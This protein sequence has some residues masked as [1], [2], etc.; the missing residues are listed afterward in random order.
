MRYVSILF[1][2]CYVMSCYLYYIMYLKRSSTIKVTNYKYHTPPGRKGDDFWDY[3]MKY[4]TGELTLDFTAMHKFA[5][6]VDLPFYKMSIVPS[7]CVTQ[8]PPPPPPLSW[9]SINMLSIAIKKQC[10]HVPPNVAFY[11]SV[12]IRPRHVGLYG[13]PHST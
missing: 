12:A 3:L 7:E 8:P 9:I 13:G 11:L 6:D 1:M 5:F 10:A 4:R 2:F